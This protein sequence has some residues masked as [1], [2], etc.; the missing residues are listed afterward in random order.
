MKQYERV[1]SFHCMKREETKKRNTLKYA[2]QLFQIPP[3]ILKRNERITI[4]KQKLRIFLNF[5]HFFHGPV[6]FCYINENVYGN[7]F[8]ITRTRTIFRNFIS[9]YPFASFRT[10]GK[11]FSV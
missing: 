10:F 2:Q 3:S 7:F 9:S 4:K 1:Y 5:V 8:N 6:L 11:T